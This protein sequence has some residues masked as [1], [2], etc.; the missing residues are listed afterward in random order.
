LQPGRSQSGLSSDRVL[1]EDSSVGSP[2][3]PEPQR[4][5]LGCRGSWAR[6]ARAGVERGPQGRRPGGGGREPGNRGRAAPPAPRPPRSPPQP[7]EPHLPGPAAH[8]P[9]L[10]SAPGRP[11]C[12]W[13]PLAAP[14]SPAPGQPHPRVGI[15]VDHANMESEN[16]GH[17]EEPL[18]DGMLALEAA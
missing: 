9:G 8:S 14:M 5:W 16:H 6:T 15:S 11:G 18:T 12:P 13:R 4:I 10:S 7:R 3:D 17:W 1:R 2:R